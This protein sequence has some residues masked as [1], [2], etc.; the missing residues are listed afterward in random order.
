M[1]TLRK[2][3]LTLSLTAVSVGG[4]GCAGG[5]LPDEETL[6]GEASSALTVA[7]ET[8]DVTA[9]AAISEDAVADES[10]ALPEMPADADGVCDLEGRRARILAR[11]DADG[12]GRLEAAERQALRADLEARVGHPFAVR[13]A[14]RHR[15]HV[16]DRLRW[17]F[18]ENFDGQLS[19]DERT[20]MID[21][22]EARCQRIRANLLE[23]FDANH[24]GSLDATERQAV[25]DAFLA[26]VRAQRQQILDQYDA[27]Q[28]GVLDEGER[29]ALRADRLAAWEARKAQVKAQFDANGDG[30]LDQAE[31]L[32]LKQA[33]QQRI[34]DGRDAE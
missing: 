11:Y 1:K 31:R 4:L 6:V 3:L 30:T 27:N 26:R 18:D 24:D 17:V 12:S 34:I 2:T 14:L 5:A 22:L 9:D 23:R 20:A 13:F 7:E 29:A 32:A 19:S 16:M 33:I 28:N 10:I 15:A 8:G 25:K 21:A